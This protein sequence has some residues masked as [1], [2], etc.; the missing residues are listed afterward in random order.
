M[1]LESRPTGSHTRRPVHYPESDGRPMGETDKHVLNVAWVLDALKLHVADR[2]D[3]YVAA[4]NFIYFEE[5]NPRARVSPDTYVVL[6][7]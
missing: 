1:T 6:G 3:V 4:N 7:V 5:G 2:P